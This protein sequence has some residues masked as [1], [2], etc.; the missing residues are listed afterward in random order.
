MKKIRYVLFA[1]FLKI[2][3]LYR[4]FFFPV[5]IRTTFRSCDA[6]QFSINEFCFRFVKKNKYFV[7]ICFLRRL[8]IKTKIRR[9]RFFS[10]FSSELR[11]FEVESQIVKWRNEFYDWGIWTTS[12]QILQFSWGKSLSKYLCPIKISLQTTKFPFDLTKQPRTKAFIIS[13]NLLVSTIKLFHYRNLLFISLFD[14]FKS[15]FQSFV[16][17]K[18]KICFFETKSEIFHRS[19]ENF[20]KKIFFPIKLLFYYSIIKYLIHS[21]HFS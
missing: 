12:Q 13:T 18:S 4:S 10:T 8:F 3:H 17:S 5:S 15:E 6:C 20:A 14:N 2:E 11:L 16:Q 1:L 7:T 21:N 19:N 9:W